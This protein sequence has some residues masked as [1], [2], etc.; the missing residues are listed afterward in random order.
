M[1]L[2]TP[3]SILSRAF[4]REEVCKDDVEQAAQLFLDAKS[5]AKILAGN[6]D[7]YLK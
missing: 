7:A 5:S 6:P 1:Q 3:S 4:G 2:L